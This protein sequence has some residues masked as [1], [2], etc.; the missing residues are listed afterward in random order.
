MREAIGAIVGVELAS[1]ARIRKLQA[2]LGEGAWEEG[3][4][5]AEATWPESAVVDLMELSDHHRPAL[6]NRPRIESA[7]VPYA[8]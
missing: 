4:E 7:T 8:E 5:Q 1:A 3:G 2:T 6:A